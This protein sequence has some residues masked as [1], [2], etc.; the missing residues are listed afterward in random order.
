MAI[1][2]LRIVLSCD[3]LHLIVNIQDNMDHKEKTIQIVNVG[4]LIVR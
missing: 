1:V 4:Y 3:T 2:G